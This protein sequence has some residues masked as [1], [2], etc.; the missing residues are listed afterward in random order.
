MSRKYLNTLRGYLRW[1]VE[2]FLRPHIQHDP[3]GPSAAESMHR[4]ESS[5]VRI[6]GSCEPELLADYAQG[7]MSRDWHVTEW[8]ESVRRGYFTVAELIG[9]LGLDEAEAAKVFRG[10]EIHG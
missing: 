2:G 10:I 7:K 9:T 3:G 4:W 1:R 8:R 6:T 5:G